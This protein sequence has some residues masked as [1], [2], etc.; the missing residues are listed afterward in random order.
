M[1]QALIQ[2]YGL[3]K[4]YCSGEAVIRALHDVSLVVEQRDFLAILGRSGSGKSTLLHLLGLLDR[5][6]TGRYAFAGRFLEELRDDERAAMRNREIGF[7]FQLPALLPRATALENVVLP[8]AYA[9]VGRRKRRRLAEEALAS[10]GLSH[11]ASH[12]PQQLSGGEQQRVAIARAIVNHPALILADE[13]TGALDSATSDE[14]LCLF[15]RLNAEGRTII[16]V[17]HDAEV[18]R[19][20]R[21]CVTMR[22]GSISQ[23]DA[24]SSFRRPAA[25]AESMM[26]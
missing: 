19:R 20:A 1:T 12:W 2:T 13:P 21:R 26:A 15:E 14:I 24:A 3:C 25:R 10:V 17:T 18:A 9:A 4:T 22:D 7:V 8:L 16:V 11:R 23:T 6:D 5:P